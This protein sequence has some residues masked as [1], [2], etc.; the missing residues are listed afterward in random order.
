MSTLEKQADELAE[1]VG[2]P[3]PAY[4]ETH[5]SLR[6]CLLLCGNDKGPGWWHLL[7]PL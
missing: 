4:P 5:V 7:S 1:K 3:L 6:L 2:V